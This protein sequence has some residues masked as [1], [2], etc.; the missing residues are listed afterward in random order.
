M[1]KYA[2][3]HIFIPLTIDQ[4]NNTIATNGEMTLQNSKVENISQ[5]TW[6][7]V[8][9]FLVLGTQSI[10][11]LLHFYTQIFQNLKF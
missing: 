2:C 8:S 6:E 4:N 9:F 5:N 1:L 7:V 3:L 10:N 11:V